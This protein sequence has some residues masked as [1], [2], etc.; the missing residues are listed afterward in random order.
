MTKKGEEKFQK[1]RLR[2]SYISV[3]LSVSL[4]LFTLGLVG[5]F[6]LYTQK[7]S[8]QV[9][10][11]IGF[12]IYLHDDINEVD[13]ERLQKAID[14]A[15]YTRLSEYIS[16]DQAIEL[17]KTDLGEDF[18]DYLDY[19]PLLAAIEVKVNSDY[20]N[21]DSLAV[22]KSNLARSSKIKE[23]V[24]Q[25]SLIQK[26][27]KNLRIAGL[28]ML[29]FSGLLLVVAIALINN[30]IR[31]SIYSRR[32]IIKTMQLV[33]ATQPFIRKPF[34]QRGI[35]HGIYSSLIAIMLIMGLMYYLQQILPD[36]IQIQDIEILAYLFVIVMA[37]G[38][39]ISWISTSLAVRKFL[40]TRSSN[41]Y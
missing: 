11:D 18:M 14:V 13:V 26:V 6:L 21:T 25:E 16:K 32:F 40:R 19:N 2:G 5:L 33:G 38:I 20:A 41:L 35:L 3:I 23:V 31:L 7:I 37:L 27:Q 9:I 10:E 39:I 1:R 22:I 36:L 34:V 15:P 4:V 30:S 28:V 29:V 12:T 17:L 8:N 24:Y